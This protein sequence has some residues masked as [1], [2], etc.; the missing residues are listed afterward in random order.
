MTVK[1]V[2]NH[3]YYFHY[4]IVLKKQKDQ[5][6]KHISDAMDNFMCPNFHR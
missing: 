6:Y 2:K 3:N 1:A 5:L 4:L